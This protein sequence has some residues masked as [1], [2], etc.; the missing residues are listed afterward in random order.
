MGS[1]IVVETFTWILSWAAP[2]LF[3]VG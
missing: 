3:N 2:M 1:Y